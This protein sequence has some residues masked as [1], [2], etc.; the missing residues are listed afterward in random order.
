VEAEEERG[1]A[2]QRHSAA[3]TYLAA[4]LEESSIATAG[5]QARQMAPRTR[6]WKMSGAGLKLAGKSCVT[7]I[8]KWPRGDVARE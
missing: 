8:V 7:E 6:W 3:G 5:W 1:A 2:P 4:A